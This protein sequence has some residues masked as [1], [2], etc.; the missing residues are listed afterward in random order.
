MVE[1][2]APGKAEEDDLALGSSCWEL[3]EVLAP[4][5]GRVAGSST[6]MDANSLPPIL[7]GGFNP[8]E[9]PIGAK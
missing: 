5:G 1:V 6:A 4:P 2:S 8:E 3:V 7:V 9:D